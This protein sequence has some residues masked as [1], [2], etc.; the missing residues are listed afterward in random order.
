MRKLHFIVLV[1]LSAMA[2]CTKVPEVNTTIVHVISEQITIGPNSASFRCSVSHINMQ[3][4]YIYYGTNEDN[5]TRTEMQVYNLI[6]CADLLN[7]EENATYYYY[8]EFDNGFNSMSTITKT[9][10]TIINNPE[11]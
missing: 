9:F 8:Y 3:N 5:M 4:I 6:V 7:L 11:K 10:N 2:A 1:M